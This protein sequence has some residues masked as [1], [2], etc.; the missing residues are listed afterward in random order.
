VEAPRGIE[1]SWSVVSPVRPVRGVEAARSVIPA[2][3]AAWGIVTPWSVISPVEPPWGVIPTRC[4]VPAIEPA[5]SVVPIGA[6]IPRAP[7]PWPDGPIAPISYP[8][9]VGV[10]RPV[11]IVAISGPIVPGTIVSD[12]TVVSRPP[13]VG[14][15]TPVKGWTPVGYPRPPV[16]SPV[17]VA[18]W[19]PVSC[20]VPPRSPIGASVKARSVECGTPVEPARTIEAETCR[21]VSSEAT[22]IMNCFDG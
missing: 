15:G 9:S 18:A 5:R 21:P 19:G 8:R 20:A 17:V 1:T 16:T 12:G 3:R 6:V 11:V 2:I 14:T 10:G 13:V 22:A 4:V 7:I